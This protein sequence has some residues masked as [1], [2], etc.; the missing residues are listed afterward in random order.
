ME[1]DSRFTKIAKDPRFKRMPKKER[2]IKIDSRFEKMFTD[3]RFHVKS[4]VD[5]R[6][7]PVKDAEREDLHKFYEMEVEGKDDENKNF[8]S[9]VKTSSKKKISKESSSKKKKT[10][11]EATLSEESDTSIN[12]EDI[13][14]KGAAKIEY[15]S[16]ISEEEEIDFD[17]LEEGIVHGWGNLDEDAKRIENAETSRFAVCNCDWD[18]ISAS[19]L[20]V[21]FNSFKQASGTVKSVKVYPSEYGIERLREEEL[22]GPEEMKQTLLDD[23]EES[24]DKTEGSQFHMEKLREYQLNRMKYYYAVVECDSKET[25]ATIYEECDDMEYEMSGTRMDLR[26]IPDDMTFDRE[27]K[28]VATS[29]PNIK[30]YQP[31]SFLNTALQ[32]STV[33]L[34][35]DET[36]PRRLESTMRKF[37]KED[38]ENMD[39]KDYL[40]SS[41]GEEENDAENDDVG[42]TEDKEAVNEVGSNSDDDDDDQEMRI[43]KYR[44]LMKEIEEKETK[45]EGEAEGDGGNMQVTWTPGLSELTESIIDK[46]DNEL[47]KKEKKNKR[48]E[49]ESDPDKNVMSDDDIDSDNVDSNDNND[50]GEKDIG[51]DDPFFKTAESDIKKKR[52]KKKNKNKMKY[53]EENMTEEEKKNKKELELLLLDETEDKQHFNLKSI[54]EQEKLKK[55]KRKRTKGKQLE[56]D[57]FEVNVKD[58]RFNALYSSHL[59]A[60]DPSEPNFKKT[61][62]T[63]AILKET[64]RRRAEDAKENK[65]NS[66]NIT[67]ESSPVTSSLS[68]LVKSV[69]SKTQSH[70]L[71]RKQKKVK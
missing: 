70:K 50:G 52:K 60:I 36:D 34:T 35:W 55:S 71:S 69:K 54:L 28:S 53:F 47:K 64:Q 37:T 14:G 21:L 45:E 10:K 19:D 18:K 46:K 30:H 48:I 23:K 49:D 15:D 39:F 12:F 33:R 65:N 24:S 20:F 6:G 17:D 9:V 1:S 11:E 67:L 68:A 59:Y 43:K 41:S 61:K 4:T 38:I 8:D 40:A 42:K 2:K 5:K 16:D 25:S 44:L 22:K 31:S 26:F 27:P 51:F 62:A 13:R 58:S 56:E 32:Q 29:M 7:K 57:H 66:K 63:E 3:D